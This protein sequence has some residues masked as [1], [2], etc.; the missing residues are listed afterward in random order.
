[1]SMAMMTLVDRLVGERGIAALFTEHDMDAVFRFAQRILVMSRGRLIAEGTPEEIRANEQ[2]RAIYL[3]RS[4]G[5]QA[6]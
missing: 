4:H 5:R 2:V 1:M 6:A 3:G